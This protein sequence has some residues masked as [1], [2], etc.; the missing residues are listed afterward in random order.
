MRS[1]DSSS[2]D[3]T[4]L[5]STTHAQRWSSDSGR[6]RDEIRD[7]DQALDAL[8]ARDELVQRTQGAVNVQSYV[9]GRIALYLDTTA[10]TGDEELER[11]RRDVADAEEAVATLAEALDSDAVRSRTTSL[12]RTVSR[13]MTAWAQQLDLEHARATA[14]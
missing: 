13:Q 8:A 5:A 11:L 2:R 6:L 12:L 14:R 4:R 3:G 10:D 1:V 9:R 7:L